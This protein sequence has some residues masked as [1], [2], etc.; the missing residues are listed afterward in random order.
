MSTTELSEVGTQTGL[1]P[2][3]NLL[4]ECSGSRERVE[5]TLALLIS[6]IGATGGYLFT[7]QEAGPV[8]SFEVGV[9]ERPSGLDEVVRLSLAL[10][11]DEDDLSEYGS[12]NSINPPRYADDDNV[13]TT[14]DGERYFVL[15]L[16]H[17][18]REGY[19]ITGVA[20]LRIGG[21]EPQRIPWE[22]SATLSRTLLDLG[23]VSM[24]YAA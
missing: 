1:I 6:E 23:D 22:L 10:E 3:I 13:W 14:E 2:H 11:Q 16:G 20:L 4:A 18:V 8:C 19:A 9:Q 7:V 24:I 15:Q 5:Q 12:I 17:Q 21:D